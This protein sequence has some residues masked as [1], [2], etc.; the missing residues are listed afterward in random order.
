MAGLSTNSVHRVVA[1]ATHQTLLADR[2]D[3]REVSRAI[4][5]VVVAVRTS[6]PLAGR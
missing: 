4:H 5:D 3:A 2:D 1:G 6:R